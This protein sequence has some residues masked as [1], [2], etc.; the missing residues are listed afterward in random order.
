MI[1]I[2]KKKNIV[3]F[4][5]YKYKEKNMNNNW[6]LN[7]LEKQAINNQ[8]FDKSVLNK[9][10]IL[11]YNDLKVLDIGCSNGFK[12]RMLFDEYDN[13]TNIRCR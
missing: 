5:K 3:L 12:T 10:G 6:N 13:I 7:K 4:V 1:S 11:K 8:K 2:I 9:S